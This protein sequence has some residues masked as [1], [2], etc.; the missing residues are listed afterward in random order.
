[1]S[2]FGGWKIEKRLYPSK[3]A[4]AASIALA[5]LVAFV[6]TSLLIASA[7]ADVSEALRAMVQGAFGSWNALF[8]TLVQSTAF[9]FT[10]LAVTVAFRGRTW[11]IGAEGQFFAGAM[12]AFWV[13]TRFESLPALALLLL[14]I[15]GAW[16]A[17]GIWGAIPGFLKARYGVNEIIV[18]VMMNFIILLVLSYLLSSAWQDPKSYF[19]QTAQMP[20]ATY[21]PKLF[22]KGRLH[23]GFVLALIT[24]VFVYVLLWKTTLGYEIRAIGINPLAARYKGIDV[25]RTTVVL[26]AIS[27]AIAAM[28][29]A[30]EVCGVHHR[31]R[32]DISIGY[33]FTGIIIALLGRL[34]PVGV[35]LAAIFF[36]AL[37]NGAL[38]MQITTGVP[39]ALVSAIQGI[40]LICL[41]AADVLPRY[42]L[43]PVRS[44]AGVEATH[45][46][47]GTGASPGEGGGLDV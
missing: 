11:N 22:A 5:L 31:L 14:I 7:G 10:G 2:T 41:L 6:L 19:Y 29:G 27:G 3:S 13:G 30:S 37:V 32:L 18:T 4:Q 40:T 35:V 21:F 46:L 12:A 17:G 23:L 47:T 42:R 38:A 43:T 16:I 44:P 36:G 28:G 20:E 34:H 39:V 1:M 8:E 25:A 33:G 24:A 15:I 26:M 45:T 9:I